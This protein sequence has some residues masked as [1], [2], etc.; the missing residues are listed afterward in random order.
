[1]KSHP[2]AGPMALADIAD[3][4]SGFWGESNGGASGLTQV[5]VVRNG[6]IG[7]DGTLTT[8]ATR[9]FSEK[10]RVR[11]EVRPG[12]VLFTSSGDI[13]KVH[14]AIRDDLHV[15]NFV[16]RI[17][18]N[19]EL[20]ESKFLYYACQQPVVSKVVLEHSGGTTIRNLRAGFFKYPWVMLPPLDE[21]RRLVATLEEHLS[22]IG[23]GNRHLDEVTARTVHYREALLEDLLAR[24]WEQST[25]DKG[26]VGD[27]L[28]LRGG[29]AYSSDSW[30]KEGIPVIK[31][32]NVRHGVVNLSGC[33]YVDKSL[34]SETEAFR[35]KQGDLLM[36]LTGEIGAVGVYREDFEARL[37]QRVARID[38]RDGDSIRI[39]FAQMVFE[40]PSVRLLMKKG[41]KGMAQPNISPKQV[42]QLPM[43]APPLSVQEALVAEAT[44]ATTGL[45]QASSSIGR[46][47]H[48]STAL[49]TA[50]LKA[51]FSGQLSGEPISV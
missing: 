27:F 8:T 42:L 24:A 6:D 39:D 12:D 50:V 9:W 28:T 26:V 17:R 38:L 20:V 34:A 36:T 19:L 7:R 11:A 15:S 44:E 2:W 10:E 1:M 48:W 18:P 23:E 4:R 32:A 29:F 30:V 25:V 49:R 21:Q 35:V 31:I 14:L 51:A 3:V 33:S 16:R 22:R 13:G 47:T 45:S 46:A 41:A 43:P 37:N 40:A 5:N